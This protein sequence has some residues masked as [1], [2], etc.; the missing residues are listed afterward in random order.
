MWDELMVRLGYERYG[1]QGGDWGSAITTQIGRDNKGHCAAI[2]VNMPLGA[3]TEQAMSDPDDK[4]KAAMES[5]AEYQQW[6]SGYS[7]QQRTRPQTVGYGLVDSPVAQMAWIVEK[8]WKW[9]DNNGSPEDALTR[10]EMLTNVMLYWLPACGA[11]SA[12]LYWESFGSFGRS[13]KVEIP[14]GA[15]A[16]PREIIKSPR[17]WCE[18]SYN[19][20]HWTDMPEGGHFAAFE[21]PE[22]FVDDLRTFFG[23]IR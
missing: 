12:R 10:D 2:H 17:S 19:I 8:F 9:T 4:D 16:F 20:T 3:P 18:N 11:S 7:T 6:D 5:A 1:A 23:T 14:S 21:Q 15:A 13:E 22:L